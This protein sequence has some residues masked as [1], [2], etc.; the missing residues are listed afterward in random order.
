MKVKP[1]AQRIVNSTLCL[2][3]LVVATCLSP[4]PAIAWASVG[5]ANSAQGALATGKWIGVNLT[6]QKLTAYLGNKV[7]YSTIIS[8]GT[9]KYPTVT[10]TYKIYAKLRSQRMRG[11]TGADRYDL[12]NV[13]HV[14]YFHKGY[15]IHGTYW[16]NNFGRR[17]SHGC[18][19]ANKAA[20]AWLYNWAPV[21]TPVKVHY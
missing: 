16:H 8:S 15:A 17:M 3:F 12:P 2:I 13:P 20:A 9:V 1:G 19:N 7:V 4:A 21:G 10:G 5:D 6:K 14:M 11:G 18:V